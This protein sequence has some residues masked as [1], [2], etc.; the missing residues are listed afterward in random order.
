MHSYLP[1]WNL[2]EMIVFCFAMD[3]KHE[4]ELSSHQ[5]GYWITYF[6]FPI[7]GSVTSR[8]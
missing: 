5:R 8:L 3:D 1:L 6:S 4:I 2:K 7:H